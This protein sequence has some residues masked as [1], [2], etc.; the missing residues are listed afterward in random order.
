MGL[1]EDYAAL[2][3]RKR[4]LNADLKT[5]EE[6]MAS[7]REA[8]LEEFSQRGIDKV[9]I[10]GITY[11][12]TLD[13]WVSPKDKDNLQAFIAALK[14]SKLGAY[15]TQGYNWRGLRA[16]VKEMVANGAKLP[17]AFVKAAKIHEGF[18]VGSRKS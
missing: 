4:Q 9:T 5:T 12:P 18:K 3:A 16:Y 1:I 14:K 2:D 10:G 7:M 17:A 8:T 6:K 11:F 13:F 15:V